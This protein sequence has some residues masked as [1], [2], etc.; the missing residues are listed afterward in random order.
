MGLDVSAFS[1]LVE[2]PDAERDEHGD[3]VDY[4]NY[5]DFYFNKDFPGRAEGL[6]EGM[7]YKLGEEGSGLSTGYGR[8]SAWRDELANLAGYT[9]D[10][11]P[12]DEYEKRFPYFGGANKA[13]EGPFYEQ[14]LFSDCDGTIGP[15]VSAKLAKDYADFAE[16]AEA[17]GG[18]FWEKYQEWKVA[19]EVAADGGAVVFH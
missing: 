14:I 11:S 17:V 18:Y 6:K 10:A 3:L 19:F 9:P 15:V 13:G 16:K 2:A 12:S 7:T 4:D 1:K 5:R 8:Y